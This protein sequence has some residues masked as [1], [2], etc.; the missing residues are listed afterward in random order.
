MDR[1]LLPT[2]IVELLERNG[3]LKVDEMLKKAVKRH[4]DLTEQEL[5]KYLMKME[6][7]GLVRVYRMPRGKRRIELA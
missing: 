7:Q 4:E 3:A 2:T 1:K 5:E 6:I